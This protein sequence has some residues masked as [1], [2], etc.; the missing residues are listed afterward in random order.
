[1][2]TARCTVPAAFTANRALVAR[3]EA[4]ATRLGATTAQV[5]LAWLL[6]EDVVPIPGTRRRTRPDENA[7][8]ASVVLPD[9]VR[10]E[11]AAALPD[12]EIVGHRD[13]REVAAGADR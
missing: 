10:R 3:V 1:M 9:D 5:A 12:D 11:L 8:A 7:D 2:T 6:A 13:F 4:V